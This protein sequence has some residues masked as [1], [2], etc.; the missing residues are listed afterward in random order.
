MTSRRP[1]WCPKTMKRWPCWCP[2]PILW[3][4]NSFLMQ[5]LPFVPMNSIN[6][7]NV[8][9]NVLYRMRRSLVNFKAESTWIRFDT[10]IP[11]LLSSSHTHAYMNTQPFLVTHIPLYLFRK[12][13]QFSL[14]WPIIPILKAQNRVFSKHDSRGIALVTLISATIATTTTTTMSE[15]QIFFSC[16]KVQL[17]QDWLEIPT[18]A[19]VSLFWN[20][21]MADLTS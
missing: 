5:T 8:S 3:E 20:T 21:N 19:A 11:I 2:K 7:G 15:L 17:P 12:V 10:N 9:E 1:Y 4:L 13:Y 14:Y 18:L 6:S 16:S